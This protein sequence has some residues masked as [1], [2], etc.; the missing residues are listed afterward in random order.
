MTGTVDVQVF[1]R[2][3]VERDKR[4]SRSSTT[5]CAASRSDLADQTTSIVR[6]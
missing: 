6:T 4:A 1:N 2:Q 5:N 3:G